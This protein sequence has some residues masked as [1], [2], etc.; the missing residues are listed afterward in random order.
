[1]FFI[2]VIPIRMKYYWRVKFIYP[3]IICGIAW[4]ICK[5]VGIE[6]AVAVVMSYI[7]L[8]VSYIFVA[9]NPAFFTSAS[10]KSLVS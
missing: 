2:S 10:D 6:S 8:V 4:A 3:L 7:V 9:S 5:T 1:M